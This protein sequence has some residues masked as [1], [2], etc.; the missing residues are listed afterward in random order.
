MVMFDIKLKEESIDRDSKIASFDPDIG[1]LVTFT[2]GRK[3]YLRNKTQ[4]L[5]LQ[6]YEQVKQRML[7]NTGVNIF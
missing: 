2:G 4:I 6:N 5:I 7:T 3:E 1:S